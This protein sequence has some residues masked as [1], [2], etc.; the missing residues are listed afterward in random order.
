MN[1]KEHLSTAPPLLQFVKRQ[2]VAD[3]KFAYM[4][5]FSSLLVIY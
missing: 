5:H 1:F 3:H 4:R 2:S